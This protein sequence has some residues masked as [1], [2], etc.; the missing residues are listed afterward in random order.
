M[1]LRSTLRI[2][3][4][5][6][7][8]L[9][10]HCLVARV[11]ISTLL[12]AFVPWSMAI[13][14]AAIDSWLATDQVIEIGDDEVVTQENLAALSQVV[15]PGYIEKMDFPE[16]QIE[17]SPVTDQPPHESYQRATEKFAAQSKLATNGALEN[18][19]AGRPF[20]ESQIESADAQSAGSMIAW[21]S[22]FRWNFYGYRA[23]EFLMCYMTAGNGEAKN[24]PEPWGGTGSCDRKFTVTFQRVYLA[25]L[26][27]LPEQNYRMD[28]GDSERL[29]YKDVM[30]FTDPFDMAGTAFMI[31]RPLAFGEDDQVQSYLPGERRVRRLSARERAD[32]FIGSDYTLDDLEAWS[33]KVA[34]YDWNFLGPRAVIGVVNTKWPTSR[35][36]GPL[37]D[38][39]DD[40]WEIRDTYVVSAKPK[41]DEHPYAERIMFF[42]RQTYVVLMTLV[43]N[44]AGDLWKV[45]YP[46]Y[47]WSADDDDVGDIQPGDT[48]TQWRSSVSIDVLNDKSSVTQSQGTDMP[49]V[50]PKLIRRVFSASA[51][52][53]GR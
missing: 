30:Q 17:F 31:E 39:P 2:R 33:G 14:R 6:Q 16:V 47:A 43:I 26:A 40:R 12:F 22:N 7:D 50:D 27:M 49:V 42:D 46:I 38:I 25:H 9:C 15:P 34:D 32:S 36:Q 3:F 41:W 5:W 52:T 45:M 8:L 51:L 48:V 10:S 20:S 11:L 24:L 28:V 44:R 13:D 37:S 19:T 23:K 18:Y 1:K 53:G 4:A 35:F 29:H 21:N